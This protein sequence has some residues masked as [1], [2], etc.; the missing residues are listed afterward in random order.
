MQRFLNRLFAEKQEDEA[1]MKKV[2]EALQDSVPGSLRITTIHGKPRYYHMNGGSQTYLPPEESELI[3]ALAESA[4]L[5]K[6]ERILSH[7]IRTIGDF[8][9]RYHPEKKLTL[10]KTLLPDRRALIDPLIPS[11]EQFIESWQRSLVSNRESSP[12]SYEN[13]SGIVAETGEWY[14]SKSELLLT[15]TFRK[16]HIPFVYEAPLFLGGSVLYPDFTLLNV[17][18]RETFY[19]EHFGMIGDA[20]YQRGM[21]GKIARYVSAGLFPGRELLMSFELTDNPIHMPTV[22]AIIREFLL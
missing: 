22:N 12:N 17:R 5:S 4:Y 7:E 11:D 10:L 16:N 3:H 9:S 21:P 8:L 19:W 6:L 14:R 2:K 1:L 20:E 13:R 18:T 15:D